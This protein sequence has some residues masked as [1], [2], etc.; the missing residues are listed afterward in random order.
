MNDTTHEPIAPASLSATRHDGWSGE[1]MA[2]FLETLAETGVVLEACDAAS[3]SST[4]AYALRRR[5]PLFAEAWEKA[6]GIA[7][8]RLADTLLGRAIEGNVEQIIKDGEIVAEKHFIDN[9]LGLAV[10]KRL[11]QRADGRR[12]SPPARPIVEPDWEL[13]L[14]ALRSGEAD[15]IAAALA[16]LRAPEVCEVGEVCDP[17][18]EGDEFDLGRVWR[19]FATGDWRTNYPPP[20]GFD[21][22]EQDDW[23]MDGYCRALGD[24]ELAALVAAGIADPAELRDEVS[25]EDDEAERDDFFA[26]LV[27]PKDCVTP[28]TEPGSAFLSESGEGGCRIKSGKTVDLPPV[29]APGAGAKA[30]G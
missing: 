7:R 5:E 24:D 9:R 26:A 21:G 4:A 2:K 30:S 28:A 15:D 20:P 11:D 14:T 6:L 22:H 29:T 23:G 10:L 19:E 3:K 17:P 1:A 27:G 13:A 16:M 18:F 25:L 8:D 12:P